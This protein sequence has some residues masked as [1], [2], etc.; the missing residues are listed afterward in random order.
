MKIIY[1]LVL[2]LILVSIYGCKSVEILDEQP[3]FLAVKNHEYALKKECYIFEEMYEKSTYPFIGF[4]STTPGVGI[5]GFPRNPGD[6]IG[7]RR[8]DI[9]I[10]ALL[11][12]G[13]V[14][15][16]VQ[17]RKVV[18]FEGQIVRFDVRIVGANGEPGPILDGLWL[19]DSRQDVVTF[20]S[21]IVEQVK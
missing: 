11:P 7:K 15:R 5:P 14:F 1:V 8:D 9:Y 17:L 21:E 3:A 19:T 2:N 4:H 12:A 20:H 10:S 18:A 13:T 16:V 6:W